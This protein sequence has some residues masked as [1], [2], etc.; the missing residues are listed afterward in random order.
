MLLARPEPG[1]PSWIVTRNLPTR[2][3]HA[4]VWSVIPVLAC[5]ERAI[6]PRFATTK[7][8]VGAVVMMLSARLLLMPLPLSNIL[9]AV[10]VA[11]IAFTAHQS[12]ISQAAY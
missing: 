3:V 10:L 5:L 8:V 6:Y 2:H 7:R 11:C 1:F 9:P 12:P 4:A